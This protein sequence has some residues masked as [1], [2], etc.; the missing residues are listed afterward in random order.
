M[1]TAHS[2]Y[3]HPLPIQRVFSVL[4]PQHTVTDPHDLQPHIPHTAG[5]WN[6]RRTLL[7]DFLPLC[8]NSCLAPAIRPGNDIYVG[9]VQS[10][11]LQISTLVAMVMDHVSLQAVLGTDLNNLVYMAT[12]M[13]RRGPGLYL[14]SQ[15][16][17][18]NQV[19]FH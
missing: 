16:G 12:F 6:M 13:P 8:P 14:D 9:E 4:L 15:H 10:R 3:L 5:E 17:L 7:R 1:H 19:K 11:A 2:L 18:H